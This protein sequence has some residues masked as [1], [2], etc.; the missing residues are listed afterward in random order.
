[1]SLEFK[2]I[3]FYVHTN[4]AVHYILSHPWWMVALKM[5]FKL[6]EV[7]SETFMLEIDYDAP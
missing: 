2:A 6:N 1:M 7:Y 4:G 5:V 3:P